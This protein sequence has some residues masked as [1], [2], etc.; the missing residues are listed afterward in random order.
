[1]GARSWYLKY[2]LIVVVFR[3][4]RSEE[5]VQLAIFKKK[6][7]PGPMG[8]DLLNWKIASL[9]IFKLKYFIIEWTPGLDIWNIN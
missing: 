8:L 7:G 4:P 5:A 6:S 1:M 3:C 2:K 9:R